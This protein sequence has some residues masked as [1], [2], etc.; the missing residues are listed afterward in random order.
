MRMRM[1]HKD[2][3]LAR[4][5]TLR[6]LGSRESPGLLVEA[7]SEMGPYSFVPRRPMHRAIERYDTPLQVEFGKVSRR[8]EDQSFP[9][10][11]LSL[12]FRNPIVILRDYVS[13]AM[14]PAD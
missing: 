3:R 1:H 5:S 12:Q 4:E 7:L 14:Y 13:A 9:P 10:I 11:P 8:G 2:P 6:Q